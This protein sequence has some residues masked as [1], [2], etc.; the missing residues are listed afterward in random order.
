M[1]SAGVI[2]LSILTHKF[3][4]FNSSDDIEALLEIAAIFGRPAM[5]RCALLHSELSLKSKSRHHSV[6]HLDRTI[7]S[8]IPI[9]DI[10]PPSLTTI[11]HRLNPNIYTPPLANPTPQEAKIHIQAIDQA[12]DLCKK[13]LRLDATQRLTA[14]AAL[15]HPLFDVSHLNDEDPAQNMIEEEDLLV[16]EG[17]CGNLHEMI[18]RGNKPTRELNNFPR[19]H[20]PIS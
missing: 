6:H 16:N 8:N 7:I 3:P 15:Q 10:A 4:V 13:L 19:F 1:W 9:I 5:E 17:K 14:S 11:V 18:M 20:G 12:I 2:L